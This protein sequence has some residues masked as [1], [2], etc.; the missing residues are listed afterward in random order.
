MSDPARDFS[1][2]TVFNK[3][4]GDGLMVLRRD[5]NWSGLTIE[6]RPSLRGKTYSSHLTMDDISELVQKL[7]KEMEWA[8]RD[9]E[10]KP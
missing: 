10:R 6:V 2:W 9:G 1:T 5:G 7:V 4:I 8:L 3:S